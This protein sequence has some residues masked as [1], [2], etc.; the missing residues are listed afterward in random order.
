MK[1]LNQLSKTYAAIRDDSKSNQVNVI[2][3]S[4]RLMYAEVC[5]CLLIVKNG[6]HVLNICWIK[7]CL[8]LS[9]LHSGVRK[10]K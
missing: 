1:S 3:K 5:L 7:Q 6:L 4:V 2:T 9:G 10:Y 8:M